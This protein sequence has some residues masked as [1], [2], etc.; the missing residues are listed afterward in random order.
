MTS[1]RVDRL[2]ALV[3]IVL[4]VPN[5]ARADLPFLQA[6][7]SASFEGTT[8]IESHDDRDAFDGNEPRRGAEGIGRL[9]L[10]LTS[11]DWIFSV[12]G[13]GY[14]R[15]TER[16]DPARRDVVDLEEISLAGPV[17]RDLRV[18]LG[19]SRP[20]FGRG[21]VLDLSGGGMCCSGDAQTVSLRGA[22]ADLEAGATTLT[23]LGGFIHLPPLDKATE[24]PLIARNDSMGGAR[25]LVRPTA[26]TSFALHYVAASL[27]A[28]EGSQ[29]AG[30]QVAGIAAEIQPRGE[31]L[32]MYVEGAYSMRTIDA[33]PQ[34]GTGLYL[35]VDYTAGPVTFLLEG[36]DYNRFDFATL[37][38][39]FEPPDGAIP[40]VGGWPMAPAVRYHSPPTLERMGELLPT[41]TNTLG[42][43]GTVTLRITRE[44]TLDVAYVKQF[45][46]HARGDEPRAGPNGYFGR[47]TES[48]HV[49]GEIRGALE[50]GFE[51]RAGG[52]VSG[53]V[54]VE[55]HEDHART[56]HAHVETEVPVTAGWSVAG[57][58]ELR[59][60][61]YIGQEA[62][63]GA[64]GLAVRSPQG[65]R[66]GFR[67]EYSDEF[68][69]FDP[70]DQV[71][72]RRN[73]VSV[74]ARVPLGRHEIFAFLGSTAGGLRCLDGVC[75]M[76]PPFHGFRFGATLRF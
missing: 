40:P 70:D 8:T 53:S 62:T 41:D 61:T 2:L 6:S 17:V 9:D 24:L 34:P 14:G 15:I 46:F 44:V 20:R 43:R 45:Y 5:A 58:G 33:R 4:G 22:R 57:S 36:K 28:P 31:G 55:T 74:D 52:G 11:A 42:G 23:A 12:V 29:A 30:Q 65:I 71:V 27:E 26:R 49:Y 25:V 64:V 16:E 67:Y 59:L 18:V 38:S 21:L 56:Q 50:S 54:N 69:D 47:G 76:L 63:L 60:R 48:Q 73:F 68:K 37:T 1:S 19:D 39:T 10:R 35:A 13:T 7:T 66:G 51:I 32:G 75:R 72:P 3:A